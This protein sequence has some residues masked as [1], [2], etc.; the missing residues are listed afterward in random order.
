MGE[1]KRIDEISENAGR[2]LMSSRAVKVVIDARPRGPRGLLAAEVILGRSML[3]HL[4]D[5]AAQV[6]SPSEPITIHAPESEHREL[7]AL[8]G[9]S[10]EQRV[11]FVSGPPR[12][13]ATVLRTDRFYDRARFQRGVRAG[14]SPEAAVLW[15]LDRIEA[16]LTAEEELTRRISYQPLGKYW[17][18]PVARRLA[19]RLRSTW[20]RPNLLTLLAAAFLFLAAWLVAAGSGGWLERAGVAWALALALILDTADGRLARLQGTS[21]AFGRWLDQLLDELSDLTLHAAIAWAA[22]R[23]TGL[24]TWLLLGILYAS[25]KYFFLI[26]SLLGDELEREGGGAQPASL[27]QRALADP[28]G[29]IGRLAALGRAVGHADI[30]WHLWIVLAIAGRLDVALAVYACYFPARAL[31]GAVRKAVRYA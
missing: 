28:N 18:F 29:G 12:T 27:A 20:V 7:R 5:L 26:Q 10:L 24:A 25:G 23:A 1:G 22:Y 21:S 13:D 4:I 14:R 3:R 31:A 8:A 30:R 16:L 2:R 19:E 15:R 11:T 6:S 9:R 17:A